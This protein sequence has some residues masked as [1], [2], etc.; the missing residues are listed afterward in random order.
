MVEKI[1]GYHGTAKDNVQD[2]KKYNFK[3]KE[4]K[5]HW[6]GNGVYFFIESYIQPS[7]VLAKKWAK[8]ESWNNYRKEYT[9]DIYSVLKS[10]IILYKGSI[11]NLRNSSGLE[12][13]NKYREKL[14]NK[15]TINELKTKIDD[16]KIIEHIKD[17][18]N[19]KIVIADVYIKFEKERIA[20]LHSNIPNCAIMSVSEASLIDKQSIEEVDRGRVKN[21]T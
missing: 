3:I 20:K 19:V 12:I 1:T 2:I 5:N 18:F 14:K 9:Y 11:L 4:D 21:E 10:D 16:F 15:L 17:K 7:V 8:A 6:L 13:F